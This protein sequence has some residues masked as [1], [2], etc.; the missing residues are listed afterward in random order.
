[1]NAMTAGD[2]APASRERGQLSPERRRLLVRAAAAEFAAAGYEHASL[3]RIIRECGLS[4]SSF[5]HVISSKQ[6]L[7]DLVLRDLIDELADTLKV[8]EP[9]EFSDG[10]FWPKTE[11]LFDEMMRATESGE[12]FVALGRMFYL[13]GTPDE[14]NRAVGEALRS[15]QDWVRDV[16]VV[17]QE[18][19][20]VRDDLPVSLQSRLVFAVLRAMD[21]WTIAELAAPG[22]SELVTDNIPRLMRAQLETIRRILEPTA[23]SA[24]S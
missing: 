24:P 19:G 6:E 9:G 22:D 8:P 13:S 14:A 1:M 5:Y 16:L 4:K 12:S 18:S 10:S 2:R 15:V 23:A 21:E 11:R 3:N 17:G 20:A 7:F